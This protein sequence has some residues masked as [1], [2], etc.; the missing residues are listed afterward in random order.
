M[1][2]DGERLQRGGLIESIAERIL[3]AE[4]LEQF[5]REVPKDLTMVADIAEG[6]SGDEEFGE[7]IISGTEDERPHIADGSH[8]AVGMVLHILQTGEYIEQPV[9]VGIKIHRIES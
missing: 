4:A 5:E 1:M 3:A 2:K 8:R 7:L 9:Y 6:A